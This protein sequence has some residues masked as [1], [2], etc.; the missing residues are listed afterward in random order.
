MHGDKMDDVLLLSE[1]LLMGIC[2][3]LLIMNLHTYKVTKNK[4]ILIISGIFVL[5]F[6]QALLVFLSEFWQAIEFMKQARVLLFVDLLV[7]LVIYMA[8]VKSS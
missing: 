3:I 8:T 7:V 4:K 2:I 1:I 5:F 6:I